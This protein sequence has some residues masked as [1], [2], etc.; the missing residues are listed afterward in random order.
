MGSAMAT[1]AASDAAATG[2]ELDV[3]TNSG[4]VTLQE[5]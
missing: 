4:S 5:R 2:L 3:N 1:D